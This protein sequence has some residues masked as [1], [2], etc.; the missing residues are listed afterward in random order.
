MIVI[1]TISFHFRQLEGFDKIRS[2]YQMLG[3]LSEISFYNVSTSV[4]FLMHFLK[5]RIFYTLSVLSHNFLKIFMS[6]N[7]RRFGEN[8]VFSI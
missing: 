1:D 7:C 5:R 4:I 6:R 3:A 2:L 8:Q